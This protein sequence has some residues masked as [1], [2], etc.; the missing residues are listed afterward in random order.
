VSAK[1]TIPVHIVMSLQS[2]VMPVRL[3]HAQAMLWLV[4][5]GT[6]GGVEFSI[7]RPNS[8]VCEILSSAIA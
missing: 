8:Y 6:Q 7:R 3:Q 1:F 4:T 2:L 5:Q